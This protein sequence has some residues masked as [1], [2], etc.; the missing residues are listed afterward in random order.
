MDFHALRWTP[1]TFKV[2]ALG[3]VTCTLGFDYDAG[4]TLK[5]D[6]T[7]FDELPQFKEKI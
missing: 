3:G 4:Y 1:V 6:E 5:V 2:D 7:S